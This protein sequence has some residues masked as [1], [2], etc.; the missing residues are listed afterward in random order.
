MVGSAGGT[1]VILRGHSVEWIGTRAGAD[2][3]EVHA[4]SAS[5]ALT[6]MLTEP[7]AAG[8]VPGVIQDSRWLP[9]DV[10]ADGAVHRL[11][12][13][14]IPVGV[15]DAGQVAGLWWNEREGTRGAI[16]QA[17]KPVVVMQLGPDDPYP[18]FFP[19]AINNLGE[20]VGSLEH[21][22]LAAVW[23]G[24]RLR[25]LN[26]EA[27]VE[28]SGIHRRGVSMNDRGEVIGSRNGRPVVWTQNRVVE[29]PLPPGATWGQ[30][31]AINN[32]GQV[33]GSAT[34]EE[35]VPDRGPVMQAVLWE[36]GA[37]RVLRPPRRAF[38]CTA[39]AINDAGAVLGACRMHPP[40]APDGEDAVP[41]EV[42]LVWENGVAR[43]L[44]T[45][46]GPGSPN[47]DP[48]ACDP[49]SYAGTLREPGPGMTPVPDPPRR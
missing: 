40:G 15:N 32:L 13:H 8:A 29:L 14:F 9:Y 26:F 23:S 17:G 6:G 37:V 5:G 48:R 12:E 31:R 18:P 47:L 38:D 16:W 22:S 4:A 39:H 27:Q 21:S 34:V 46:F 41:F 7:A 36:N 35:R 11:P 44:C 25:E 19:T 43:P 24:G 28:G 30:A 33:V 1:A 10:L 2:R 49:A 42:F 3:S 45:A 20:V